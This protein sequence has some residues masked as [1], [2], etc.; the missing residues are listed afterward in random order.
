[1]DTRMISAS[2]AFLIVGGSFFTAGRQSRS[3][4]AAAYKAVGSAIFMAG[5][6]KRVPLSM[7]GASRLNVRN[8]NGQRRRHDR[9]RQRRARSAGALLG[10]RVVVAVPDARLLRHAEERRPQRPFRHQQ[11]LRRR[12]P[13]LRAIA[14]VSGTARRV[15]GN[16]RRGGE[17]PNRRSH[18]GGRR[19]DR[20]GGRD[21][22]RRP[23]ARAECGS[24][25]EQERT[26][27]RLR[28]ERRKRHRHL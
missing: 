19:R 3:C 23:H 17:Q 2:A 9:R 25:A 10:S 7:C 15:R 26:A 22:V 8:L 20:N 12:H 18:R 27:V 24:N 11:R 14:A 21:C 6:T 4:G 28:A 1:M 13:H 16:D 5:Y